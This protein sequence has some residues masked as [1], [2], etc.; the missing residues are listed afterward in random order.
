MKPN[1]GGIDRI[2]RI[3]VGLLMVLAFF[4]SPPGV[5]SW[6][7]LLGIFPLATGFLAKCPTYSLLGVNTCAKD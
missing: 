1:V 3:I 7:W 2:V 4:L 6:L 5:Y